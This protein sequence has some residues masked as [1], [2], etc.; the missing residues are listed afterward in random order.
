MSVPTETQTRGNTLVRRRRSGAHFKERPSWPWWSVLQSESSGGSSADARTRSEDITSDRSP[1]CR[2]TS[3][4][5]PRRLGLITTH[6]VFKSLL[7][8]ISRHRFTNPF[9]SICICCQD[10]LNS[11]QR[12]SRSPLHAT[13]SMQP[14]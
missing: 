1:I 10:F 14:P 3:S 11:S 13:L 12:S 7:G 4:P 9:S 2:E 6:R 8:W 5:R